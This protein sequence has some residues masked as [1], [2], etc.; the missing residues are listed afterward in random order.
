V[1]E[2]SGMKF[3]ALLFDINV[4]VTDILTS[5][6]DDGLYRVTANFLN[7]HGVKISQEELKTL[8]F[9]LNRK[10][11][12]ESPEEFPEFDVKK[13]FQ[14]VIDRYGD[15][16]RVPLSL[17]AQTAVVFRSA[18]CCR[19]EPYTGVTEV[20]SVMK[21]HYRMAAVSDGQSIWARNELRMAGLEKFF[22]FAVISGDHGFRKP[23]R[24]MFS[25]ALEQLKLAP[26]EAVYVGNDMYR[27]V[28]G[29]K[30]AGLKSIFFKSNQ[31]EQSFSGAEP[32]YIIYNF[33]ELPRAVEFL[34]QHN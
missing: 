12:R 1:S 4:T 25:L 16:V 31:G 6:S 15:P 20:L 3:K 19:L 28:Y 5:E 33:N 14:T 30:N 24:R 22:E 34:E 18:S 29:A 17:A 21:K 8:Y 23:D 9:E 26:H 7:F 27:D 10:Q 32:D 2:E 13:I 11:R